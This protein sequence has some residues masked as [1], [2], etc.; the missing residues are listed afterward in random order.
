MEL[1]IAE[2][3]SNWIYFNALISTKVPIIFKENELL[4]LN[5][6]TSERGIK[7]KGLKEGVWIYSKYTI[8]LSF[9]LNGKEKVKLCMK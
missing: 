6:F 5:N 4:Y 2:H 3:S 9:Y 7:F 1:I 8:N